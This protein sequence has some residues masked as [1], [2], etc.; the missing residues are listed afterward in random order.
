M[1]KTILLICAIA[2]IPVISG[3]GNKVA[4]QV[5]AP[6]LNKSNPSE[7]YVSLMQKSAGLPG[8]TYD[9]VYNMGSRISKAK[10]S[11]EGKKSRIENEGIQGYTIID[12]NTTISY[13]PSTDTATSMTD[14]EGTAEAFDANT[15]PKDNM[16]LLEQTTKNGYDCQMLETTSADSGTFK[17][18]MS[19]E[20]GLP[21]YVEASSAEGKMTIEYKNIKVGKLPA[22]TFKVPAGA[23]VVK[24]PTF[25]GH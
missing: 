11:V 23:K 10:M 18:C 19:E 6:S 25:A 7:Y 14:T 20:F 9:V 24:V 22:E 17:M 13:D 4:E 5:K 21:V 15:V 16:K 8:I 12:Q 2:L 1:K 3:C